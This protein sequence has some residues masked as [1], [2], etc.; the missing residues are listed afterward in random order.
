MQQ[1]AASVHNKAVLWRMWSY[2]HIIS[3]VQLFTIES[4]L[5]N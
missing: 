4:S 1:E 5:Y 2:I 3:A